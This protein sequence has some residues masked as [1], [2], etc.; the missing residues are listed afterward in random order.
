MYVSGLALEN[1]KNS[2][3]KKI[4]INCRV[5][6][7]RPY[8]SELP[9]IGELRSHTINKFNQISKNEHARNS[10]HNKIHMTNKVKSK[11][12]QI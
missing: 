5:E 8:S 4:N 3:S 9:E 10:S 11:N 7:G 2:V 12:T 1:R 6:E